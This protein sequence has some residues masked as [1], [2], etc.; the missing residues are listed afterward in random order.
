M[1]F[2]FS[3]GQ[4]I[5]N[6]LLGFEKSATSI[7]VHICEYGTWISISSSYITFG[8]WINIAVTF[9]TNKNVKLYI[10]GQQVSSFVNIQTCQ[11]ILRTTCKIGGSSYPN[12]E[13]LNAILDELKIFN[14]SL[15]ATEISNEMQIPEPFKKNFF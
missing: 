8:Q 4:N 5:N 14:R 1:I 12:I 11:K 15:S 10:N 2:D 9:D 13:N 3:N 7:N 6:V